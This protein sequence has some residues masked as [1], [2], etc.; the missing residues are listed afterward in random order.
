[1]FSNSLLASQVQ[2]LFPPIHTDMLDR[3]NARSNLRKIG[4][5]GMLNYTAGSAAGTKAR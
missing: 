4:G 5:F 2:Y 1:M 3:L